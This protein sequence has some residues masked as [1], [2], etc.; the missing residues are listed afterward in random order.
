[1]M[2]SK[3]TT[4][5]TRYGPRID[6]TVVN[7]STRATTM[8]STYSTAGSSVGKRIPNQVGDPVDAAGGVPSV[9]PVAGGAGSAPLPA[10]SAGPV[11]SVV[12]GRAGSKT[13]AM[14]AASTT[15][16][17]TFVTAMKCDG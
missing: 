10:L 7:V 16:P 5:D 9:W 3:A 8:T 17:I 15:R 6:C 1:M 2:S 14:A 13:T 12:A 4:G 11:A